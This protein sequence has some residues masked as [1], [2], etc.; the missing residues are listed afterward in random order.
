MLK[1]SVWNW[2]KSA[3]NPVS[4]M[5]CLQK[6][7]IRGTREVD[8]FVE[9]IINFIFPYGTKK[10]CW[11]LNLWTNTE[12]NSRRTSR[13]ESAQR[14]TYTHA[15]TEAGVYIDRNAPYQRE[16]VKQPCE[17]IKIHT[18]GSCV[19]FFVGRS[20]FLYLSNGLHHVRND[21][22]KLDMWLFIRFLAA[23]HYKNKKKQTQN[24]FNAM[25][26][27]KPYQS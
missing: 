5:H 4:F 14:S 21:S 17:C 12:H 18:F 26:L 9:E 19:R 15:Y 3:T 8:I 10:R 27:T 6:I 1:F 2:L 11:F 22:K 13:N 20:L 25:K 16:V 24:A 23:M 7:A